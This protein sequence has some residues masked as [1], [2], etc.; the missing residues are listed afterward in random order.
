MME[1]APLGSSHRRRVNVSDRLAADRQQVSL[2]CPLVSGLVRQVSS[3][4]AKEE[5]R[6]WDEVQILVTSPLWGDYLSERN[7]NHVEVK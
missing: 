7:F 6:F 2:R 5:P 1:R 3:P 4:K